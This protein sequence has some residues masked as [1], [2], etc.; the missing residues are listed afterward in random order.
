M[1]KN[2]GNVKKISGKNKLLLITGLAVAVIFLVLNAVFGFFNCGMRREYRGVDDKF[3]RD[4]RDK[5]TMLEKEEVK[6][7]AAIGRLA[8]QYNLLGTIYLEKELYGPAIDA[9]NNSM[10]YGNTSAPIYYSL[11]LAYANRSVATNSADDLDKAEACYRK[12]IEKR[13]GFQDS[14][15][16]LA[17]LLF[18]H[19]DKKEEAMNLVNEIV[20]KNPAFYE[21][22]FAQGRFLYE[23]G[24]REQALSVYQSLASDLEKLPPSGI[25]NEYK[26]NCS[27]NIN[28]LI[29]ELGK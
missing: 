24:N 2:K 6:D 21:A 11:G 17:V 19:R 4:I 9:L 28:T 1:L 20:A 29:S 26:S 13:P 8:E 22:R 12:A 15:Y 14:M 27:N 16:G 18:Y 23:T 25:V 10:K 7:P 5:I 3:I